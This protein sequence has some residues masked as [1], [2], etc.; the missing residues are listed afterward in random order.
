MSFHSHKEKSQRHTITSLRYQ[1]Q[2]CSVRSAVD[3]KDFVPADCLQKALSD[4][5]IAA[6]LR[7]C[8]IA[9][10]AITNFIRYEAGKTFLILVSI[11]KTV[12]IKDFMRCGFTDANLPTPSADNALSMLDDIWRDE[13]DY[14]NDFCA[15]QW[16]FMAPVFDR[17]RYRYDPFDR[18]AILP[19][20]HRG[21][22]K[23]GGFSVVYQ[24][25]FHPAHFPQPV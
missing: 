25:R 4:V 2:V 11:R 22:D 24:V 20:T 5:N 23:G 21:Q 1:L 16:M 3:D 15:T 12:A 8:H 7:H 9:D 13:P 14:I 10:D 19:F 18:D 17:Q 6:E